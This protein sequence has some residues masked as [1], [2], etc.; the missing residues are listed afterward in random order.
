MSK[1]TLWLSK[2]ATRFR[3]PGFIRL[4]FPILE[5][6]PFFIAA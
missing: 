2:A 3:K 1:V 4:I 6:S 5:D